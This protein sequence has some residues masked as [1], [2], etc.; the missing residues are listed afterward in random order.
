MCLCVS[1]CFIACL[2]IYVCVCLCVL[3]PLI[4]SMVTVRLLLSMFYLSVNFVCL[5]V[6]LF[7]SI[8]ILQLTNLSVCQFL[9]VLS[10]CQSL[11]ISIC[12]L[13]YLSI[14]LLANLSLSLSV[15]V[16]IRPLTCLLACLP[17]LEPCGRLCVFVRPWRSACAG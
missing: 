11:S 7:L 3:L 4:H 8:S 17:A 2:C 16:H 12:L 13:N 10:F 14:Y 15:C 1:V 6:C 5:S 9:S